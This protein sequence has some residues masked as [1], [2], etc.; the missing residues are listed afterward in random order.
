MKLLLAVDGSDH[1]YEAVRALKYLSRAEE[2]HI[3][4]VLDVP[5]P[6]YPSM[7][8]EVT[9]EFYETA[10]RTMREEGTRL[11]ERIVS[12]LPMEVGPVT[13][14]LVVGS[15]A[16]QIIAMA[17][18]FKVDLVLLGTRG[19]GPI[20]E[21]LLGSVAHRVLTFAPSAKLILR[22]PLKALDKV[23]LPL[24]GADDAEHALRFLQQRPFRNP[25]ML[26]L[27]TVLPH[28][29]PP[30]PVND[31]AAEQMEAQALREA[32]AFL[33][34]TAAKLPALGHE[35]RVVASLG[36]PVEGILK[37]AGAWQPDLILMGSRG[38]KGVSRLVL[39]SVSHALLHQG[40]YPLMIFS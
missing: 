21:R 38:R 27:F 4:H 33:N 8:P 31:A 10:E 7:I 24:R 6:A 22:G 13:K 37:E 26:T 34:D 19:F 30:W 9:R 28:T 18:Q 15:P 11:L 17:E 29:K 23:L 3:V 39:G 12:L 32:E 16:D 1:S 36:T 20:K 2:L 40:A 25:P 35:T 5:T 14:H